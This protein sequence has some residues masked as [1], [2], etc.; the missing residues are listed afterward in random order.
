MRIGA[1]RRIILVA[2]REYRHHA[3]SKGFWLTML[4]VPLIAALAGLI[5]QWVQESRATRAF[6][7]IDQSDADIAAVVDAGLARD[8]NRRA[9]IALRD[10]AVENVPAEKIGQIEPL[11]RLQGEILPADI[12]AFAAWGGASKARD[13]LPPLVRADAPPFV[14]PEPRFMR[15][16][17]PDDIDSAAPAADIGAALS[18]YLRA[19]RAASQTP[20][21]YLSAAVVVPPSYGLLRP[22]EPIQYW[23]VNI[24]DFELKSLIERALTEAS[25]RALY[26]EQ[27]MSAEVV[28]GIE[29]RRVSMQGFSPDKQDDG[30][31]IGT[32][33]RLLNIVPLALAIMLWMSIFTVANLLLLGVIEERSN[34]LIEVLLSSVSA[35]E[36]MAGKLLGIAGIGLTILA[37][38]IG[39][40]LLVLVN[41]SGP[42]VQLAHDAIDLILSGPYIPAFAFYFVV[43]YLTIASIFLGLGSICNSQQE[44][45]SLLTPL[46]F[47]L[48]LPFFLIMPML[49][50]PNG[51]LATT[52]GWIPI[53]TPFVMM[54]R[55][56]TNPP[57]LEV[58]SASALTLAFAMLVLW[59][60]AR[61]FKS[62][63]L[64]TGQPPRLIE[65]WRMMR[66][67]GD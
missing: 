17:M 50:D 29:A 44:A 15:V 35:D 32:Q 37:A 58:L 24:N 59:A 12:D 53:Y 40:G 11:A 41:G 14:A 21:Y 1:L 18:P 16:E 33:D 43:G 61:L 10:Y 48:M 23:S 47:L 27:G 5:P 39:I 31:E 19:E 25:K 20:P 2:G 36:F 30:G 38:W 65:I 3:K 52:I 8:I 56:S 45:Q 13:I 62:A 46:V 57:W 49:E 60:M 4:A 66:R 64:R 51:P 63:V 67:G 9:L 54:V 42:T 55:L 28:A 26:Q 34:R 6:V 22:T 7:I